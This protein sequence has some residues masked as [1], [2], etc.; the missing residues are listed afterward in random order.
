M[1][2]QLGKMDEIG[3]HPALSN[4]Y[5]RDHLKGFLTPAHV[6]EDLGHELVPVEARV[7]ARRDEGG[8]TWT[9]Q[10]LAKHVFAGRSLRRMNDVGHYL[11]RSD[12][13]ARNVGGGDLFQGGAR[14][15]TCK[16]GHEGLRERVGMPL[17]AVELDATVLA[18]FGGGP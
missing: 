6:A 18:G 17:D 10:R 15:G 13:D 11:S 14:Q 4:P 9:R 1:A 7:V 3:L 12:G 2:Q 5:R 16:V 8:R